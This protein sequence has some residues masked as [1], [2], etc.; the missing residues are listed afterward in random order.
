MDS[1]KQHPALK[2][3]FPAIA[4]LAIIVVMVLSNLSGNTN[5]ENTVPREEIVVVNSLPEPSMRYIEDMPDIHGHI[6]GYSAQTCGMCHGAEFEDWSLSTHSNAM[7]SE[8]FLT[9]LKFTTLEFGHETGAECFACHA[10]YDP[11]AEALLDDGTVQ[12]DDVAND[13]VN[14]RTCHS[15]QTVA[16]HYILDPEKIRDYSDPTQPQWCASCHNQTEALAALLNP[17]FA[18]AHGM[19]E[20]GGN[21]YAEW[22][23]SIYSTPGEKYMACIDCHGQN[24]T[25]T[26][27][28]WPEDKIEMVRSGFTIEDIDMGVTENACYGSI[29]IINTG[30]GHYLPSGDPGRALYICVWLED[31]DG[32]ILVES[33][34]ILAR[35]RSLEFCG[36]DYRLHPGKSETF[37]V[38]TDAFRRRGLVTKYRISYGYSPV[39]EEFLR[40]IGIEPER[41][42]IEEN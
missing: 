10:P 3:F 17:E 13:G 5:T 37:E 16:G 27:H 29:T 42:V 25:G 41:L 20:P 36:D 22:L 40:S 1:K 39:D 9:A 14:C 30:T 38:Y 21:P 6:E 32:N 18:T 31:P 2:F 35:Y 33:E 12:P 7:K 26:L 15:N 23:E 19:D 11:H 34:H 24:G 4:I 28:R 8:S